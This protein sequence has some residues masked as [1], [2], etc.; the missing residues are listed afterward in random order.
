MTPKKKNMSNA[1]SREARDARI[2]QA[3][4]TITGLVQKGIRG[5]M[6]RQ[7]GSTLQTTAA[8]AKTTSGVVDSD[9]RAK[10]KTIIRTRLDETG[11][12]EAKPRKK[13]KSIWGA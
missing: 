9:R 8:H 6:S 5:N 3:E 2:K 4:K 13:K 7:S 11:S 10:A 12:M 1:G